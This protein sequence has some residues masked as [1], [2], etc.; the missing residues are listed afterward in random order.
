MEVT[1]RKLKILYLI[2][3]SNFGGAQRYVYDLALEAK[4]AGHDVLV[5]FG[6]NG[7]LAVKL[8]EAGIRTV[9]LVELERDI[10]VLADIQTF[11]RL[12]DLL[13]DEQPSIIHLNSSKMG[14]IGALAARLH[15]AWA[16][17]LRFF[18]QGGN[19]ARI[20]FTGHGWAFNEER[21]DLARFV[22]GALHWLTIELTHATISVSRKTR[23]QVATLPM[24][25]HKLSVVYNGVG[26]ID[27]LKKEDAL[28]EI[29][30]SRKSTLLA[31]NPV[32]IGTIAELH[33]NKGLSYAIEGVAQLKKQMASPQPPDSAEFIFVVIGEGEEHTHL[34]ALITK[35]GLTDVVFLAGQKENA[36]ALLSA[37]DIFILPSI[38]EA[39]PYVILEAGKAGLPIVATAVGG[40]PEVIDDMESGIL[41][42]S[43][44][45]SE[46]ARAL[47]Y[48]ILHPEKQQQFGRAIGER[49]RDRFNIETMAKETFAVYEKITE[50]LQ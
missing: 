5:G 28:A 7:Q 1:P 15:N 42:Q 12:L 25:W 27:T 23:D 10:N 2:T 9:S 40:I 18:K 26:N 34:D 35:L 17:I 33:N 3:K 24:V 37:F 44:N 41:I 6:G 32:V 8:A 13:E 16:W 47:S 46:V 4:K 21:G 50:G 20:V 36:A 29:F 45:P 31:K 30:G 39:F 49:I 14:A 38:T 11:F 43:K 19:P 48:L 22:I